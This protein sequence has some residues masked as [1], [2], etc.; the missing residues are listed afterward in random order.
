MGAGTWG[1]NDHETS[2]LS[3]HEPHGLVNTAHPLRL[4]NFGV[5]DLLLCLCLKAWN[6]GR[7]KF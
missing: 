3:N 1:M 4:Q 6:I 5:I 2:R 7:D